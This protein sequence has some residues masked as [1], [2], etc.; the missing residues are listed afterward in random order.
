MKPFIPL[1]AAFAICTLTHAAPPSTSEEKGVRFEDRG[2]QV[3]LDNGIIAATINK[4]GANVASLKFKGTEMIAPATRGANIYFSMDGGADYRQ[5]QGCV[6]SVKAQS[7]EMVDVA[8]RRIWKDEPQAFDIEAHF[9]LCR[10]E[11]G[12]YVYAILDHPAKYP[13]TGYGEWRMVWRPP[14]ETQDWIC[15]DER[16]HWQ[17]PDPADYQTAQKMGIKEIVKLTQGVRAG[18]YDCKYDFNASYHDIGCWGHVYA[19]R[20]L[21]AWMVCGGYDFFNDGPT[22]QDL[23]ASA[24]LNHIYFGRNH[25]GGSNPH[26]AAGETWSKIYGPYLLYC[27]SADDVEAM[28]SDAKERVKKEKAQWPYPWLTGVPQY[29][30]A[31]A[32]GQ[33]AGQLIIKDA[34]KPRLSAAN[35]WVGVAQPEANGNWQYESKHYQ[36]WTHADAEGRFTIPSVRPGSYILY[37]F[38]TG[39]VGEFSKREIAVGAGQT[40]QAGELVWNVP[41][42]G[43]IVWEIGM[44]D[45]SAGEFAHGHDYFHGYGWERFPHEFPNPLEFTIGKSD[46]AKD[47]NYAQC[48]YGTDNLQPWKWRIHFNLDAAPQ[49]DATLVLSLA[50]ADS[51]R[52]DVFAN[53]ESKAV[54]TVTPAV[55]GGDALLRESIHAKYGLEQVTIPA[56]KLHAGENVITLVEPNVKTMRSH[57]MYDYLSLEIP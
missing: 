12:L 11:S 33:V 35:A 10:G 29:P 53:D 19:Q 24:G 25:Y 13:A 56:G 30:P 55:Q 44:P 37:A 1:I 46:P 9:V 50:S 54:S 16:R 41:H 47:W 18:Q 27:N 31:G 6:F 21:G 15:V 22:K 28:W 8:C 45:R 2:S 4:T 3:V 23:N 43:R 39:A 5:P 42:K 34:Q 57:V 26:L 7:P 40:T 51:A 32:R 17:M 49:A 52:I 36:Y 14:V 48:G 38:T 20:K